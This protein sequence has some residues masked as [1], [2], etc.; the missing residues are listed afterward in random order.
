MCSEWFDSSELLPTIPQH[1]EQFCE[2]VVHVFDVVRVFIFRTSSNY[3][4]TQVKEF[5]GS[6]SHVLGVVRLPNFFQLQHILSKQFCES[7]TD[8][9]EV[10]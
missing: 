4:T 6:V 5:C 1:K 2:S 3:S 9:F 8:V 10:V 7:V